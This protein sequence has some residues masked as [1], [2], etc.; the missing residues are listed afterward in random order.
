VE[1]TSHGQL[2]GSL[3]KYTWKKIDSYLERRLLA[4]VKKSQG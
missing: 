4:L 1:R 2:G 3:G